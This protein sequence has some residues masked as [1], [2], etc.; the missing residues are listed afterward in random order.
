MVEDNYYFVKG[1]QVSLTNKS[2]NLRP[3][4]SEGG[5]HAA[6]TPG[7][8]NKKDKSLEVGVC[9]EKFKKPEGCHCDYSKVRKGRQVE[10]NK[11]R[12]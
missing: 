6:S 8:E 9:L 4:K 7:T 2:F 11:V 3:V 12:L 1:C 10:K 5:S